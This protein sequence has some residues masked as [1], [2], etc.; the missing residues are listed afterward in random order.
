MENIIGLIV[1]II[2]M[3]GVTLWRRKEH[4]G[5]RRSLSILIGL[6]GAVAS[7]AIFCIVTGR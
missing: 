1:V 2:I 7:L 3:V 5:F 4:G 6:A